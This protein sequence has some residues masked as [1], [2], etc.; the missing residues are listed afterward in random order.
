[1]WD[2]LPSG[3][4]ELSK[5]RIVEVEAFIADDEEL[6]AIKLEASLFQT[7]ATSAQHRIR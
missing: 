2:V 3:V 1:M 7:V 6:P 4:R 5:E